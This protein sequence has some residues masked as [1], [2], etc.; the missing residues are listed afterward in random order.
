MKISPAA[1]LLLVCLPFSWVFCHSAP[2]D[3]GSSVDSAKIESTMEDGHWKRARQAVDAGLRTNPND[4]RLLY[5]SSKVWASFGNLEKA[6]SCAERAVS[7]EP[8][9]PDFLSQ[10]A[11]IHARLADRVS[12]IKQVTYVHAFKKEV[13][14][15]LSVDPKHVDT[16]LVDIMFLSKAPMVA[17]GD[18]KRA[19]AL[20]RE[21]AQYS[22]T[23]GNLI[24][25]R[26]G[27]QEK[28]DPLI[29]RALSASIA[30]KP[31]FYPA[32]FY[33]G[34]F[35]CCVS[36]THK[37]DLAEKQAREMIR[38]DP[39]QSGGYDILARVM[40]MQQR[41]AELDALLADAE[42]KVPDD[43]SPYYQAANLLVEQGKDFQRA[44]R[45][46][47]KYLTQEPEGR[48]P[49][50]SDGRMLLAAVTG[51]G[52]RPVEAGF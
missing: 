47:K 39:G 28:N 30:A 35:Y 2:L 49:T 26:L 14:T 20:A 27:E 15:A 10:L 21:M 34:K 7:A 16:M 36:A 6:L 25:A 31:G 3:A 23:W 5:L 45:F 8:R 9:N 32:H 41:W 40:V 13:E 43:L 50:F 1:T 38:M 19:H 46:L 44:E 22:P 48:Q 29:E 17:G 18:R 37:L 51:K 4:S 52:R 33:L 11:E 24:Q 12:V 42:A